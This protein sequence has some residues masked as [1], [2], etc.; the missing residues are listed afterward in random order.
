MIR[1]ET[2]LLFKAP[3][4]FLL[5]PFGVTGTHCPTPIQPILAAVPRLTFP[6]GFTGR[7]PYEKKKL[8]SSVMRCDHINGCCRDIAGIIGCGD[9]NG[10]RSANPLSAAFSP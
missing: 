2:V 3:G 7:L 9:G 10:I 4:T 5:V 1:A 6:D 8:F